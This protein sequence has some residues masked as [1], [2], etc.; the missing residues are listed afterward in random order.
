MLQPYIIETQARDLAGLLR[1]ERLAPAHMVGYSLG[2]RVALR[3]ALDALIDRVILKP[4]ELEDFLR[5]VA[6]VLEQRGY[7]V[8]TA[9]TPDAALEAGRSGRIDLLITDVVMPTLT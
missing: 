8:L 6:D 3:L 4:F 2:A 9:R 5:V 1:A 7:T